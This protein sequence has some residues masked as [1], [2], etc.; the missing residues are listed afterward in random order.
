MSWN[1][2]GGEDIG[3]RIRRALMFASSVGLLAYLLNQKIFEIRIVLLYI[4]FYLL[5]WFALMALNELFHFPQRAYSLTDY[6][7]SV[8]RGAT[9]REY[10]WTEFE[11][12]YEVGMRN[13]QHAVQKVASEPLRAFYLKKRTNRLAPKTYLVVYVPKNADG[14]AK[15][16]I[17]KH[18]TEKE[19]NALTDAG[20][21]R[22]EFR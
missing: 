2:A 10:R 3:Y 13:L 18:L 14:G 1:I 19:P 8:T 7:I 22:Y 11:C 5:L 20:W 16:I 12:F 4:C 9:T 17:R 21:V 6:G 15:E